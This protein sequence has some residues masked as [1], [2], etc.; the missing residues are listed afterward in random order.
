MKQP[1]QNIKM[2]KKGNLTKSAFVLTVAIP[3][4][5]LLFPAAK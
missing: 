1:Y 5:S 3:G 4:F 2:K